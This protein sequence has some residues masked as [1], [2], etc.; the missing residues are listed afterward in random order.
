[1]F[2][3]FVILLII[4]KST[5]A[6]GKPS[7][8]GVNPSASPEIRILNETQPAGGTVQVKFSLTEPR[9]ISTG[10]TSTFLD[11][12]TFDTVYGVELF[13]ATGDVFGTAVVNGTALQ[14]NYVSPNATFGTSLDYPILTIAA[15]IRD[16]AAKGNITPLGTNITLAGSYGLQSYAFVLKPGTL[17]IG[18][19]VSIQD[20]IP[21]GGFWPAGTKV[22]VLGKGFVS[23]TSVKFTG[24]MSNVAVI[25]PSELVFTLAEDT[26]LDG[27]RIDVKNPDGSMDSYYSYLRGVKMADSAL[28]LLQAVLPIFSTLTYLQAGVVQGSPG[29][30]NS[31]LTALAIQNPGSKT[32]S[33]TL[34]AF[35]PLGESIGTAQLSLPSRG[36][37][38]REL[39][40][41]FGTA[42]SANS[43]VRVGSDCLVQFLGIS[44]DQATGSVSAFA[45]GR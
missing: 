39:G 40:E 8:S 33:V 5:F 17:T 12:A 34:E 7:L 9:P 32:A 22:R 24:R 11:G 43:T 44:A 36:K 23:N 31:M 13:S 28:P 1:M 20:V 4:V 15:H 42:L 19:T 35:S 3:R 41:Y 18:G 25:S 37:V 30:Q 16:T 10:S 26:I 21:G 6:G 2:I 29:I 45:V 14:V 38:L 27:T